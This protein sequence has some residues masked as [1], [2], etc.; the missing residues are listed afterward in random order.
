MSDPSWTVMPQEALRAEISTPV[1][2]RVCAGDGGNQFKVL[3]STN[4]VEGMY[5]LDADS[6]I[7]CMCGVN[8]A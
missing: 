6:T 2:S 5:G 3:T 1:G 4:G 8:R 7:Y